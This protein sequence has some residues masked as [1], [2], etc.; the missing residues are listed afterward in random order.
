MPGRKSAARVILEI[1]DCSERINVEFELHSELHVENSLHK[2]DVLLHALAELRVCLTEEARFYRD[3]EAKVEALNRRAA[4]RKSARRR[5][6]GGGVH[7]T[8]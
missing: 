3:R 7:P 8:S 1:A 6:R 2:V 4:K 5:M